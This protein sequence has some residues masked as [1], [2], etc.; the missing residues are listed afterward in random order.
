MIN[1]NLLKNF[2]ERLRRAILPVALRA[3]L[4]TSKIAPGDF[5]ELGART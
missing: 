2:S 5:V 1:K 4:R 3:V